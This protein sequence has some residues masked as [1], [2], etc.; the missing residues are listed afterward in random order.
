MKEGVAVEKH[1]RLAAL[2]DQYGMLLTEK[3]QLCLRLHLFDDFSLSEIGENLQISRQAAY[4]I[5]HRSE[6]L[7]EEYEAKLMLLKKNEMQKA[8]LREVIGS[9]E[10]LRTTANGIVV[11]GILKKIFM[12]IDEEENRFDL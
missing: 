2:F 10:S 8:T 12:L 4:D 7:M 6:Q 1:F 11:D 3:Q 9:L 5:L